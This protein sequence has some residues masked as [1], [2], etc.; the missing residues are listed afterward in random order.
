MES[1][2]NKRVVAVTRQT[3]YKICMYFKI[4]APGKEFKTFESICTSP[5]SCTF[6]Q[7]LLPECLYTGLKMQK[8]VGARH[9]C[10]VVMNLP[11][12]ECD[13]F[14]YTDPVV[15]PARTFLAQ[16]P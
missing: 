1:I 5:F 9:A 2:F 13:A 6:I 14:A 7:N 4:F 16:L 12:E 15:V 3:S 8:A 11:F 10:Q